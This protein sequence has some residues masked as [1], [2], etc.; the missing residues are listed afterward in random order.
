MSIPASARSLRFDTYGGP[1][2]LHFVDR[3]V[4]APGDGKVRVRVRTVGLNPADSKTRGGA[5]SPALPSGIGRELAG[6]V[7]SVGDGVAEWSVGDDV[8]GFAATGS[9]AQLVI[10]SASRDLD[11]AERMRWPDA[12]GLFTAHPDARGLPATPWVE[13]PLPGVGLDR[14]AIQR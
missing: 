6:T 7:E 11:E 2:V 5:W 9:L 1:E 3:E 14:G 10:T 8:F 13:A 12:G 4:P